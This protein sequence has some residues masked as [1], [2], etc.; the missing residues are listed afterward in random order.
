MWT[1]EWIPQNSE[2][3]QH[4]L[5][6]K[7]HPPGNFWWLFLKAKL[8]TILDY[9]CFQTIPRSYC[10]PKSPCSEIDMTFRTSYVSKSFPTY[11][12]GTYWNI[13]KLHPQSNSLWRNSSIIWGFIWGIAWAMHTRGMLGFPRP[14]P[15]FYFSSW[16]CGRTL[17]LRSALW[18]GCD[19]EGAK[20]LGALVVN[21]NRPAVSW[22][23]VS[24]IVDVQFIYNL[25]CRL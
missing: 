1:D 12:P 18:L 25:F 20:E 15:R 13:P 11:T 5:F 24:S 6:W 21:W 2:V 3:G 8:K 9:H 22:M 7:G 16:R 19:S 4:F 10:F 23:C 17:L 14:L